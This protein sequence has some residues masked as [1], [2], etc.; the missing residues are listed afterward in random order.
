MFFE[1]FIFCG[2]S[3]RE[4]AS[5]R[6]T[7]FILR[8]CIGASVSHSQRRKK[9]GEALEKMQVNETG[10][11]EIG[12]EDESLAWKNSMYEAMYWPTPGF[13]G[14]TFKLC[15]LTRWDFNFC[16]QQLPTAEDNSI[17]ITENR[18]ET[19]TRHTHTHYTHHT[20]THVG[21]EF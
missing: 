7:Y 3:T 20:H 6:V 4:P 15:V 10:R 13:K 1:L 9:L 17:T 2:H 5:G 18:W 19:Q 16:V 14:K 8:A 21:A 11:V 12:K